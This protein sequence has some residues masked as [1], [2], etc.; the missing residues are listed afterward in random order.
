MGVILT[1]FILKSNEIKYIYSKNFYIK[2]EIK[3]YFGNF[4][5][6]ST[7]TGIGHIFHYI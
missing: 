3:V 1:R 6:R 7:S 5:F 4:L 2:Y